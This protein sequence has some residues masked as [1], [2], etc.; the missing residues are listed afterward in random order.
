VRFWEEQDRINKELIPRVLKLHELFTQHVEH[1]QAASDVI[2][3]FEAKITEKV[4]SWEEQDRLNQDHINKELIPKV[5]KLHELFTQHV[6]Q[7]QT[8]SDV[9]AAFEARYVR[10]LKLMLT[11]A[12]AALGAAILSLT[13]TLLS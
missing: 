8:A 10:R 3:A 11:I 2:A 6:E 13:L 1:H 9:I 7:H 4:N 5:L 12:S